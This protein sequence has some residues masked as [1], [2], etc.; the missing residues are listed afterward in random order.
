MRSWSHDSFAIEKKVSGHLRYIRTCRITIRSE[1]EHQV[2]I[3][4]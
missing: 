3:K 2:N 1:N 4:C